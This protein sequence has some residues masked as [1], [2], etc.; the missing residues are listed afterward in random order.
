VA[1]KVK[2]PEKALSSPRAHEPETLAVN[3]THQRILKS[4]LN[5][6]A[7][8]GFHGTGIRDIATGAGVSTANLYHYMGTKER[9]LFQIMDDALR[10]LNYAASII[11]RESDDPRL[12]LDRL[13]RMHVIT[14]ALSPE[15]SRVVDNQ[16]VALDG[17]DRTAVIQARDEYEEFWTETISEGVSRGYFSVVDQ[18]AARLGLLE[19]CSGVA[20]WYSPSGKHDVTQVAEIHVSLARALLGESPNTRIEAPLDD[21]KIHELVESIWPVLIS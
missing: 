18:S 4:A 21:Y 12:R 14:H 6:F 16:V 2:I 20:R 13:V 15:A 17:D 1:S 5:L 8:R 10:R 3:E 19:M 11:A 9:L 7:D